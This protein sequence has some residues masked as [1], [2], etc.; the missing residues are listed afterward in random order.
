MKGDAPSSGGGDGWAGGR[1]VLTSGA[2]RPRNWRVGERREGRGCRVEDGVRE[3]FRNLQVGR[4][5]GEAY[6]RARQYTVHILS[7]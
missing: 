4:G 5:G 7:V 3:K 1:V 2:G 6:K